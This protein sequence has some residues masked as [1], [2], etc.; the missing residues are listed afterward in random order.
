MSTG[1]SLPAKAGDPG[2][3][4]RGRSPRTRR[5]ARDAYWLLLPTLIVM[6]GVIGY[7]L[8]RSFLFAFQETKLGD[9]GGL[10]SLPS[11]LTLVNFERVLRQPV[12]SALGT[13]TVYAVLV[14]TGSVV[15][16]I[17]VALALRK[18]FPGRGL[19]R[20]GVLVPYVLPVIAATTIWRALLNS[21]YGFVNVI[22]VEFLGWERPLSFLT[23]R[24]VEVGGVQVP[25]ALSVVILFEIWHTFPLAFLFLTARLQAIDPSLEEAARLDGA[26]P[27]QVIRHVLL[28]ELRGVIALL[29]I[30]RLIWT[31]HNFTSV[32]LLTG[33]AG[34]TEIL[35]IRIFNEF[36]VRSDI[37]AA[38]ALGM[39]FTLLLSVLL[40]AYVIV[41]RRENADG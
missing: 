17:V 5:E 25:L 23:T 29:V 24:S 26:S 36:V 7:P 33:G 28:P 1:G 22:G 21:Q 39:L 35:P 19:I 3:S 4:N 11:E 31:F 37:G 13:T 30:L 20:A 32:Y 6:A 41:N 15:V 2:G 8:L 14:A 10:W 38:S 34:G 27:T 9:L 18:P 40:V 12:W 16:G